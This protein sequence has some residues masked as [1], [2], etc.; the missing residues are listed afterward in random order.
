MSSIE[1]I[2][3]H[4]NFDSE[5]EKIMAEEDPNFSKSDPHQTFNYV[6]NLP[7]CLKDNKEFIGIKLGQRLTM[8]SGSVLTHSHALPQPIAPAVHCEVCLHRI[9]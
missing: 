3:V 6:N 2:E 9:C 1:S 7:P 5:I 4:E 8:D